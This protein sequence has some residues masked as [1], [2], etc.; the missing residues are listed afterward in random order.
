M[1]LLQVTVC[2]QTTNGRHQL[3]RSISWSLAATRVYIYIYILYLIYYI[4]YTHN[5]KRVQVWNHMAYV[6]TSMSYFYWNTCWSTLH[7]ISVAVTLPCSAIALPFYLDD[8]DGQI[9]VTQSLLC[10]SETTC[11]ASI[12]TYVQAPG[13]IRLHLAGSV[14]ESSGQ[15]TVEYPAACGD[16]A[17]KERHWFKQ[18]FLCE[19][20]STC[21]K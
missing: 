12:A 18:T 19:K 7:K 5:L 10:G 3:D 6:D 1:H 2:K 16:H 14:P 17:W 21:S 15:L 13:K 4:I 9:D 20:R 11:T 8:L